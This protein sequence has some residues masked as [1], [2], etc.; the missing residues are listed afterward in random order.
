MA[1]DG[2][3]AGEKTGHCR[4]FAQE[5]AAGKRGTMRHEARYG[6]ATPTGAP[7]WSETDL[8][9]NLPRLCGTHALTVLSGTRAVLVDFVI[10]GVVSQT[11]CSGPVKFCAA[12][13]AV[14]GRAG[15][16][17]ALHQTV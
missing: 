5:S 4:D 17:R 14:P 7:E 3:K 13:W 12:M 16:K 15:F 11:G 2:G 6:Q 10:S 8:S 1:C 9:Q